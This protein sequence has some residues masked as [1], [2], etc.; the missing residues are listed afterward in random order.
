MNGHR[1]LKIIE[2]ESRVLLRNK[3]I[4][5]GLIAPFVLL[6]ILL[7]GYN[8]FSEQT[9][10]TTEETASHIYIE[11]PKNSKES[12][13]T[14]PSDLT[15]LFESKSNLN[16]VETAQIPEGVERA[17]TDKKIDLI[18]TYERSEAGYKFL[19]KYDFGRSSGMR[20]SERIMESL[21]AFTKIQRD[22]LL[23]DAGL[24]PE[25]VATVELVAL[26]M[27]SVEEVTGRTLG[28]IL[29]LIL[30]LYTLM[31]IINFSTELTTA[32]KESETLETLLSVP[33]T[34]VEMVM[35]KLFSCI[36]FSVVSMAFI[37][38]GI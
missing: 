34:R 17:I 35:G 18:L 2:K 19:L 3:R 30:V 12:N 13:E 11:A 9:E 26:D 38:V 28:A 31:M 16:F 23:L 7:Y 36:L 20:A 24:D 8:Y 1:I 33:L 4:L 29:P 25:N 27:A 14:L 6:P 15:A 32:E 5:F 10:T 37:L 22:T 21:D